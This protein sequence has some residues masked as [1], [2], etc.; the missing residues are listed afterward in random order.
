[1]DTFQITAE[2]G[3]PQGSC[4]EP[5]ELLVDTG[6]TYTTLPSSTLK[7]MSVAPHARGI[8]VLADARRVELEIGRTWIRLEGMEEVV[9]VVFGDERAPPLLGAVTLE[10]FQLA[11]DR[12]SRRLVPVPGLLMHHRLASP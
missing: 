1:M 9:L 5:L 11:A 8:F 4:Y 3:D 6:A 7:R 2:I 12:G 10:T